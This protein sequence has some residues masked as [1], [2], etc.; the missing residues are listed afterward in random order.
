MVFAGWVPLT[1]VAGAVG[2]KCGR[3]IWP[4]VIDIQK[5]TREA[6]NSARASRLKADRSSRP[7]APIAWPRVIAG[8]AI[9]IC[10]T[11]WA[12]Q[13]RDY[14]IGT[15][16]GKF[17][18]DS[19]LQLHFVTWVISALAMIVGGVVAGASTR[20]GMRHGLFVGTIAAIGIFIIQSQVIKDALPAERFF[21]NVVGLPEASG[22]SPARLGFFLLSNTV[23]LSMFGGWFG[24]ALFPTVQRR[25]RRL[26][27]GS[28]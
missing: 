4:A 3:L 12:A 27:S 8:A 1:A 23:A 18:V 26:D 6:A 13:I 14:V 22:L 21:A 2:G 17:T 20:A 10:C 25:Q 28:I 15:S 11:I 19:R 7:R 5:P 16:G 24:E 9:S